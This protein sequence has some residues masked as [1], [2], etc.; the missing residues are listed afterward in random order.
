VVVAEDV[1]LGD[2]ETLAAKFPDRATEIRT[3]PVPA[4]E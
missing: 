1:Q 3:F 2:A 4:T